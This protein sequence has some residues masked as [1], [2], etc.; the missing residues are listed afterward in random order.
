MSKHPKTQERYR[1]RA[2]NQIS[3]ASDKEAQ[4]KSPTP[5]QALQR[6]RFCTDIPCCILFLIFIIC[7]IVLSIFAFKEGDP[8]QLLYPTDSE[9]NICGTGEYANRPN[10]YFFDWTK[11]I[12]LLNVPTSVLQDRPFVCPTKQVCVQQCPNR[13]SYYKFEDYNMNRICTYDVTQYDNDNEQ[14]VRD[15]KCASY[16]I[17]SKPLFGRCVPQQIDS[18]TNS[19]IQVPNGNEANAT[20]YDSNGQPLNGSKLTEGVKYLV[21]LL[22]L[23]Q[24]AVILVEDLAISWKYI[25]VAFGL[26]AIVS[27]LWIVLMRWLATP[28]VWLGIIGFIVLL[29]VITGLAF[30]EF[31]QLREK[32]DNQ[33]IKEF[34]FVA[35]ANYYRSLSITWLIIGILSGILLLIAVLIVLVLFKRLRIALTILQE[36]STAVAY[37]FFILFWPFIPLILHIGIFAYW[38]A[39]TIYLATARKPI[40]RITGSQSDADSM[41][42]TI[43]QICDPKKWNNNAGMNVE[44]MFSEYGYDP[45]VDLDNILN[46]TGKHFKSFISFVNQNQWLPQVFSVFMFFWL[47]AFTIGL[48]ELVLAGVYARYYWDKRRFGIPRSSLG[49]SFFRAIVFHLGTIAFGSLIIAI[50]KLIRV[51]LEYVEKKV[52]DKTGR[53]ARCVFCCCRCCLF[54]LEKFLKFL[55]RNAYIITAIYGSG[56]FTSARRA[57]KIIISHPIRLLV[58]DKV[59]DFLIFLGKLCITAGIGILAFFF[60]THRIAQAENYV[61]ELHYY[62]IPL[63]LII[64]GTYVITKCFFS[65]YS[66]AVD[67]IMICALEDL[68]MKENNKNH[69]TMISNNL[70]KVFRVK[71]DN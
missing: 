66:M 34:K 65:V 67:T 13:T 60:F 5:K 12:K 25:L 31:V 36:A 29:A 11:C 9:G 15:G 70:Q 38:V 46:G 14:L 20:V 10:V 33:I 58:I 4:I 48:S 44:C 30:F 41:D 26:A 18:L 68:R 42:L 1:K 24:I 62:L 19:I 55:D 69:Q 22:N 45:Q 27:F 50:V 16:I 51:L 6:K 28:L 35:D 61:P 64:I 32:N 37:N 7:F 54:C 47:T 63:L 40:Y 71:K 49:V 57:F 23:K 2:L 17:A 43:G 56:F 21:D 3:D 52:K 8:R 59:C 53:F 39:I